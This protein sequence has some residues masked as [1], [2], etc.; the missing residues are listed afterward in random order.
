MIVEERTTRLH[1]QARRGR[2]LYAER[3]SRSS[4]DPRQPGRRVHDRHR[5]RS[6]RSCTVGL[7]G[8]YAER[9]RAARAQLQ[10]DP[11]WKDVPREDPAAD[12]H[13]A[14]TGSWCRLVLADPMSGARRQGRDRHRRRAGHRPRDRRGARG[15]GRA[16]RGRRPAAAPRRRRPRFAGRRRADG[17]RRRRGGRRSEWRR[18]ASSAAAA[19]T[20]SSTTPASTPRWRCARSRRSRVEEWRQVMDVNVAEH[21]PDLPR[22]GA[23]DARARRRADREHLLRHAV[24]RRPVPAALRHEQGRDRRAD[25]RAGEGARRR[26]HARQLRRARLHDERRRARRTP[27]SIEELRE[28]SVVGAHAAAR[29]GARRTSSARSCSSAA[30]AST[31]VTGQTIVIDGG[32]Y[33][34]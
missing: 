23:A 31:F 15:R 2:A 24:P 17:R 28:V 12:P 19:S 10:A 25:A 11:R 20:C 4:S 16:D 27:R 9:E 3:A 33:F 13:A 7:R 26:R 21:V 18:D 34:H 14:A 32:Q 30:P 5:R 22:R 29:P 1:R 8:R 6:A